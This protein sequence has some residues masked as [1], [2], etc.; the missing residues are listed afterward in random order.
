MTVK[1]FIRGLA[2]SAPFRRLNFA[3]NTNYR[4][5]ELLIQRLL[6][7]TP[8]HDREKLAWS[9]TLATQGGTG[10]GA[11]ERRATANRSCA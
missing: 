8:Y 6:G 4:F 5:V 10:R 11:A 3:P 9:T 1:E 2:I 7:R